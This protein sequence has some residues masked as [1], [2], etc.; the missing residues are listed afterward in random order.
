V[1]EDTRAFNRVMQALA[2]PRATSEEKRIRGEAL[3]AANLGALTVPWQ[4][5]QAAAEGWDLIAAMA[6]D[7]NPASASDAGVGALALRTAIRGA[8]LN[9]RTNATGIEDQRTIAGILEEGARLEGEAAERELEIL[10]VV[11]AKM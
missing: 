9:V 8:W 5:M 2:L 4:V 3:Q 7:G 11:D 10:K 6:R 1:D